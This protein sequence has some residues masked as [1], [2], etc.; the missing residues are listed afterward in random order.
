M[1]IFLII[2]V[3]G[4]R[5]Q[6]SGSHA[7]ERP[8]D[9]NETAKSEYFQGYLGSYKLQLVTALRAKFISDAPVL[10]EWEL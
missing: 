2:I 10:L 3:R 8:N 7:R 4:H 9:S 5:L 6:D 1:R